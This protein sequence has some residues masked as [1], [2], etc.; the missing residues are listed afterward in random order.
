MRYSD[1]VIKNK[2]GTLIMEENNMKNTVRDENRNA[3]FNK[4]EYDGHN[5]N[6]KNPVAPEWNEELQKIVVG[7]H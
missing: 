1:K 3:E 5:A 7:Y 6:E 2:G 4:D